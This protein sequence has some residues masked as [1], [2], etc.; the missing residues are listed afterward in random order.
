MRCFSTSPL[1]QVF[2][3]WMCVCVGYFGFAEDLSKY[4]AQPPIII[5]INP[6][7]PS[8]IIYLA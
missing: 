3:T 4:N 1:V 7:L 2:P 5:V 8:N 6:K